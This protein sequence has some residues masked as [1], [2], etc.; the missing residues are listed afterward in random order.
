MTEY[1]PY[2]VRHFLRRMEPE[3]AGELRRRLVPLLDGQGVPKGGYAD[4]D[5]FQTSGILVYRTLVLRRSPSES[6]PPSNY[7]L[8]WRGRYYEV[9]QR[10]DGDPGILRHLPLGDA[11]QPGGTPL[12]SDVLRLAVLAGRSGRLA[13]VA[14]QP[15]IAV[16]LATIPSPHDWRVDSDTRVVPNGSG[17]TLETHVRAPVGGRY[18]FWLGGSFRDRI[19]L[20]VDGR[21]VADMRHWINNAGEYTPFGSAV[22]THGAHNVVLE[23][24]GPDLHPGSGGAQFGFGPLV[25]SRD[26]DDAPVAIVRSAD[27]R[28]LCGSNLDW[29][30]A[31]EPE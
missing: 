17:G 23:Y 25:L 10:P 18:N 5:Q 3:S 19:R 21:A 22:L 9:W 29:V 6:R 13:S 8:A 31:L 28:T 2:G 12:C 4:P 1:Q 7:Q 11:V 24:Q 27:A 20:L 26:D 16:N 30:E 14:R 15:V